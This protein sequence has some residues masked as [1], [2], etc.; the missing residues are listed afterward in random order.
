M[1]FIRNTE[2]A[3]LEHASYLV[4]INDGKFYVASWIE[5]HAYFYCDYVWGQIDLEDVVGWFKLEKGD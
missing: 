1:K 3:E 2:D 5:K 4:L